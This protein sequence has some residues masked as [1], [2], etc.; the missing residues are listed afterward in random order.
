MGPDPKRGQTKSKATRVRTDGPSRS[1]RKQTLWVIESIG[2]R[3]VI[4]FAVDQ[5]VANPLRGSINPE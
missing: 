1:Q 5:T 4:S 3:D 2:D